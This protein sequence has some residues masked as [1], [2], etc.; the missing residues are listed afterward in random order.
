M[1]VGLLTIELLVRGSR[2]LKIKRAV[3]RRLKERIRKRCN[4][5]IS[6]TAFQDDRQ[7][8]VIAIA[9][10]SQTPIQVDTVLD[11]AEQE[12]IQIVGNDLIR[13]EREWL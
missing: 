4:V 12:A 11:C 1:T 13:T 3:L 6:E 10:V 7:R 5:S 8:S 2:S 9:S